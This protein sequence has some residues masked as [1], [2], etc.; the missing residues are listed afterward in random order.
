MKMNVRRLASGVAVAVFIALI[1]SAIPV[2]SAAGKRLKDLPPKDRETEVNR[3]KGD[4]NGSFQ[5]ASE[6]ENELIPTGEENLPPEETPLSETIPEA[7]EVEQKPESPEHTLVKASPPPTPDP[8]TSVYEA[9]SPTAPPSFRGGVG[10]TVS[11]AGMSFEPAPVL[12]S[13]E[14][15]GILVPIADDRMLE[16][17]GEDSETGTA[18]AGAEEIVKVSLPPST[19]GSSAAPA[20]VGLLILVHLIFLAGRGVPLCEKSGFLLKIPRPERPERPFKSSLSRKARKFSWREVE[21]SES[22]F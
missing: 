11:A 4:K 13:G 10:A 16:A 6:T 7:E 12:E 8:S 18:D 5:E 20:A 21:K 22:I 3:N 2:T 1:I 17:K 9:V 15:T 14:R 19:S